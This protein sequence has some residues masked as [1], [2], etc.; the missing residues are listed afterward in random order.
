MALGGSHPLDH[1]LATT[2]FLPAVMGY[3]LIACPEK[4]ARI[5]ELFG[6]PQEGLGPLE[7]AGAGIEAVLDLIADLDVTLGLENH[8]VSRSEIDRLAQGSLAAARLWN[9][10]PRTAT[11]EQVKGIIEASFSGRLISRRA[12]P[13]SGSCQGPDRVRVAFFRSKGLGRPGGPMMLYSAHGSPSW[14]SIVFS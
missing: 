10:N 14:V 6:Q 13:R 5:G 9:N 4:L 3:N 8:G 11:L 7:R 2:L 1:G 12:E